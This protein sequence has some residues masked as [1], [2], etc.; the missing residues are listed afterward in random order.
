MP[1]GVKTGLD[2]AKVTLSFPD[3]PWGTVK[4]VT[5]AVESSQR[6]SNALACDRLV[7]LVLRTVSIENAQAPGE[8]SQCGRKVAEIWPSRAGNERETA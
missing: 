1:P 8:P 5:F 3:C 4:P 6:S 7:S 2:A